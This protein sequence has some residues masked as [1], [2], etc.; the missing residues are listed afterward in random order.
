VPTGTQVTIMNFM[1]WLR[2]GGT[3]P[4]RGTKEKKSAVTNGGGREKKHVPSKILKRRR[5]GKKKQHRLK[6]LS[7]PKWV[8]QVEDC[9]CDLWGGE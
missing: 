2:E 9:T 8:R 6:N 3:P 7:L 4:C 1:P 5:H